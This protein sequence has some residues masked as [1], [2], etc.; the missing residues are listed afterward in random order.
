VLV[1]EDEWVKVSDSGTQHLCSHPSERRVFFFFARAWR[2][3]TGTCGDLCMCRYFG[4]VCKH[5]TG[6][7]LRRDPR[8]R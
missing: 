1:E 5:Y 2:T 3:R 6:K 8:S 4:A 7:E